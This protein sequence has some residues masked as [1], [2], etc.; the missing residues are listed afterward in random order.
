MTRLFASDPAFE[1]IDFVQRM[2]CVAQNPIMHKEMDLPE[3]ERLAI[4]VRLERDQQRLF[5]LIPVS[6]P[7]V[8]AEFINGM[9]IA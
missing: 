9:T 6:V 4:I 2:L 5:D 7:D 1:L 3:P 8:F